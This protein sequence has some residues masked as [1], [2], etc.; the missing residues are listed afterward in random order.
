MDKNVAFELGKMRSLIERMEGKF[1]P[2]Q[3]IL[4]EERLISEALKEVSKDPVE[5]V[6]TSKEM[7]NILDS[8][9]GFNRNDPDRALNDGRAFISMGYVSDVKLNTTIKRKNPLTNRMRTYNDYSVIGENIAGLVCVTIYNYS[10]RHRS[11]VK[12]DYGH[13]FIPLR[14]ALRTKYGIPLPKKKPGFDDAGN[15]NGEPREFRPKNQPLV[16]QFGDDYNPQNLCDITSKIRCFYPIDIN[17]NVLRDEAGKPRCINEKD[18]E[19]FLVEEDPVEGVNALRKLGAEQSVIDKYAQEFKDLKMDYK[20]FRADS[21]LYIRGTIYPPG[22]GPGVRKLF[23]NKDIYR[24][25]DEIRVNP[26][27]MYDIAYNRYEDPIKA[28][29]KNNNKK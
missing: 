7:F 29:L 10:Y 6:E 25:V 20:N 19:D 16:D 2:H 5:L 9:V 22:G 27:D 24:L 1:T 26:R 13:R 8:I 17:G 4:N 11:N 12:Y 23:V 21:I 15:P 28:G 18:I 14:N 3:A